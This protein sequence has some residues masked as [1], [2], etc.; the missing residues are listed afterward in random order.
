MIEIINKQAFN[1]EVLES[2]SPVLV[3]FYAH[4]CGP[5][6]ALMKCLKKI[7]QEFDGNLNVTTINIDKNPEITNEYEIIAY[8]TILLMKNGLILE[9]I[10]GFADIKEIKQFILRNKIDI[11]K[12]K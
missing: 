5:C 12:E 4:W 11:N 6:K 3:S 1:T 7:D 2:K 10:I 8:P 9:R